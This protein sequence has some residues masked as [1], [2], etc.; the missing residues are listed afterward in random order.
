[1]VYTVIVVKKRSKKEKGEGE[2]NDN[3]LDESIDGFVSRFE[4]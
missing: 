1:M 4:R 3:E 2:K